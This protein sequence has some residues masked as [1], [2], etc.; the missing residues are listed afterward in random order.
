[1]SQKEICFNV[2]KSVVEVVEG[3][4]TTMTKEQIKTAA[5]ELTNLTLNGEVTVNGKNKP[6]GY[7]QEM[8]NLVSYWSG[9]VRNWLRRDLRL[10]GGVKDVPKTTRQPAKITATKRF[11]T[12]LEEQLQTAE[13]DDIEAIQAKIDKANEVLAQLE[14]ERVAKKQP[15]ADLSALPEALQGLVS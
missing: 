11:I 1:M 3:V 15:K 10:N 8:D 14:A 2:I 13:G 7:Y 5:T 9:T 12:M 6:D 4:K